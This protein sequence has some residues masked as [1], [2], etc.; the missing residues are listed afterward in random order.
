MRLRL[1]QASTAG[2]AYKREWRTM[3]IMIWILMPV[4]CLILM[5]GNV[6]I[7][8]PCLAPPDRVSADDVTFGQGVVPSSEL[9]S[10]VGG[11]GGSGRTVGGVGNNMNVDGVCFF[12][13]GGGGS[14][15]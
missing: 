12:F 6:S 1:R 2:D 3:W 4:V 15:S 13:F 8:A 5:F 11:S 14:R 7:Y 10:C 9:R